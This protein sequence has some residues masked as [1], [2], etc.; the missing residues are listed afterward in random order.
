MQ[1]SDKIMYAIY[2]ESGFNRSYRVVYFTELDEH[3]KEHEINAALAGEPVIDG[4]LVLG[5]AP[6]AKQA[7]RDLLER[8]NRGEPL[9]PQTIETSLATYAPG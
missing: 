5:R 6:Q 2:R 9:D 3:N 8:M 4:F 7:I 1:V